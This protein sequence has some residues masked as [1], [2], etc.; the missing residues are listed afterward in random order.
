MIKTRVGY[1]LRNFAGYNPRLAQQPPP[2]RYARLDAVGAIVNQAYFHATKA[3]D[4]TSPIV[5]AMLADAPVSYPFLVGHAS[6]RLRPV[7]GH[8][9]ERRAARYRQLSRNVGEVLGVFA[10]ISR[11]PNGRRF[12]TS[13][14]HRR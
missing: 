8:R 6:A 5:G 14:M 13:A 7:A 3:A 1:N 11:S 9:Q 2:T 12:C 10:E 4:L